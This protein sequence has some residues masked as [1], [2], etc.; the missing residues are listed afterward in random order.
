MT[1]FELPLLASVDGYLKVR[2]SSPL[3]GDAEL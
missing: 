2:P 1:T 3:L